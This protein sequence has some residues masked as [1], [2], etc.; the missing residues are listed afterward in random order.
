MDQFCKDYIRSVKSPLVHGLGD[1]FAFCFTEAE[2]LNY[3]HSIDKQALL[4][5]DFVAANQSALDITKKYKVLHLELENSSQQL[6]GYLKHILNDPDLYSDVVYK[7]FNCHQIFQM[8]PLVATF[9]DQNR[10]IL[11][12]HTSGSIPSLS[13]VQANSEK[14]R[15]VVVSSP[16]D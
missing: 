9:R 1:L 13:G 12:Q 10:P 14:R 16:S 3:F 8:I 11:T 5:A 7:F 2:N 4:S 6:S 15:P